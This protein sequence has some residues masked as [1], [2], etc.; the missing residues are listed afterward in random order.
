MARTLGAG[1]LRFA[2]LEAQGLTLPPDVKARV[3]G[4]PYSAGVTPYLSLLPLITGRFV[5]A[6]A[7]AGAVGEVA[8]RVV[9]LGRAGIGQIAI[10]P[11]A[12]PEGTEE[13]TIRRFAEEVLPIARKALAES[14]SA[15]RS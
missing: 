7:L 11:F 12:P 1:R 5:D 2:T 3:A 14:G 4:V 10:Y 15:G 6:L 9:A 8:E 13:G